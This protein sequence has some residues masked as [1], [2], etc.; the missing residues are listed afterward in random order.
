MTAKELVVV[1][2]LKCGSKFKSKSFDTD[3]AYSCKKC[4]GVLSAPTLVKESSEFSAMKSSSG[5]LQVADS[6]K[7]L[8][9]VD[10]EEGAPAKKKLAPPKK[11]LAPPEKKPAPPK[12]EEMKHE[13]RKLGPPAKKKKVTAVL[14]REPEEGDLIGGLL[15]GKFIGAG[16]LGKVYE[17]T[18]RDE[19]IWHFK[20]LEVPKDQFERILKSAGAIKGMSHPFIASVQ[21]AGMDKGVQFVALER[22]R[23]GTLQEVLNRGDKLERDKILHVMKCV[24]EALQAAHDVDVLHRNLRPSNVFL[25]EG[26]DGRVSDFGFAT[27]SAGSDLKSKPRPERKVSADATDVEGE[28]SDAGGGIKTFEDDPDYLLAQYMSFEQWQGERLDT[29]ADVYSAGVMCY[30]LLTG[31]LPYAGEHPAEIFEAVKE[32][33]YT[34]LR[35]IVPDLGDGLCRFVEKCMEKDRRQRYKAPYAAL[36]DIENLAEGKSAVFVDA[37]LSI[38]STGEFKKPVKSS[39]TEPELPAASK[40][41]APSSKTAAVVVELSLLDGLR[42]AFEAKSGEVFKEGKCP[43]CQHQNQKTSAYCEVCGAE[44]F[45]HC[46]AC[47]GSTRI[48]ITFCQICGIN[49][50][51][52]KYISDK[53]GKVKNLISKGQFADAYNFTNEA[54]SYDPAFDALIKL[55]AKA[56]T[57]RGEESKAAKT[58][59]KAEKSG[60]FS[61][62][63][64]ALKSLTSLYPSDANLQKKLLEFEVKAYEKKL[65]GKYEKLNELKN[66]G[67]LKKT[68]KQLAKLEEEDGRNPKTEEFVLAFRTE[69]ADEKIAEARRILADKKTKNPETAMALTDETLEI[70]PGYKPGTRLRIDVMERQRK[71]LKSKKVKGFMWGFTKFILILGILG[72]GGYFGYEYREQLLEWIRGGAKEITG[73]MYGSNEEKTIPAEDAAAPDS[74]VPSSSTEETPGDRGEAPPAE[75]P[76]NPGG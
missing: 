67:N 39:D 49:I 26:G 24:F 32:G 65:D 62:A 4:G 61:G 73:F 43:F 11:K 28:T 66:E 37:P 30:R 53:I 15:I 56:K 23:G 27:D 34:P 57:R 16:P 75:E 1:V 48:G 36:E 6:S 9:V 35:Q 44:L 41:K 69:L 68:L 13:A 71:F 21:N 31:K 7:E 72:T 38:N 10:P 42:K 12:K 25:A 59:D 19:R 45:E 46:V 76:A 2:C 54:I 33:R 8:A 22:P 70:L 29:R 60:D 51:G 50:P 64:K 63:V 14:G 52:R 17:A 74:A 3:K 40:G 55:H 5:H 58:L 47:N 18:D 20:M